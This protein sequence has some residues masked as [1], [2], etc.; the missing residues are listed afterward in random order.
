MIG[1]RTSK[2]KK[3]TKINQNRPLPHEGPPLAK[4]LRFRLFAFYLLAIHLSCGLSANKRHFRLVKFCKKT[5]QVSCVN[6]ASVT[7]I[8]PMAEG[9]KCVNDTFWRVITL[10][11][12]TVFADFWN[13]QSQLRKSPCLRPFFHYLTRATRS[14]TFYP[15]KWHL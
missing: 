7:S 8:L 5:L 13:F 3:D 15:K 9:R 10:S 4:T 14:R 1:G 12:L 2:D 6:K 11:T